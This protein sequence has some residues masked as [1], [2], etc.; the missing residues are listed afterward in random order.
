[1]SADE[2]ILSS[3]EVLCKIGGYLVLFSIL[4]VF[5]RHESRI[6]TFAKLAATG[7]LEMTTGIREL[8]SSLPESPAFITSV[9]VLTFGGFSG[10]FQTNAVLTME[11]SGNEKRAGLSIRPYFFWKIAHASLSAGLAY[12]LCIM[13]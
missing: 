2:T 6:P 5:L 9:A 13:R 7:A 8:A 1:M 10:I 12:L 3:V 11:P 4:I